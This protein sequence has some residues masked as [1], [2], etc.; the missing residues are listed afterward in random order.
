[1]QLE[2]NECVNY[3]PNGVGACVGKV[4]HFPRY[5]DGRLFPR[6]KYHARAWYNEQARIDREYP[7]SPSAPDWF[8]PTYAGEVW[9]N[10]EE[11]IPYA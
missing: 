11:E 7:D 6:C 2:Q 9:D 4:L 5:R 3:R 8:D 1:M 10:S